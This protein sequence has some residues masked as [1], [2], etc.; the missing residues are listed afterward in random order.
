M[1]IGSQYGKGPTRGAHSRNR[2]SK[3]YNDRR[4]GSARPFRHREQDVTRG[5][6]NRLFESGALRE[7]MPGPSAARDDYT[8]QHFHQRDPSPSSRSLH[9]EHYVSPHD[10]AVPHIY[11]RESAGNVHD[12]GEP[13]LGMKRPASVWVCR[14]I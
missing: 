2:E 11:G 13:A 3:S 9:P 10:D 14:D 6:S 4:S 5:H 12:Y 7:R 1:H 8:S